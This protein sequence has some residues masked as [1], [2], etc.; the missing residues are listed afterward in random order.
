MPR[1]IFHVDM[2]AFFAAVE[3][4]DNPELKGKPVIVGGL[5]QRGVVS[6]ASYEARPF[7][8]HSALPMAKARQLCP[9]AHFVTPRMHAYTDA[10]QII[11]QTFSDFTPLVEPLSVDEAFLDMSGT[12]KLFGS[13]Q[14]TAQHI[15]DA[16][17]KKTQLT[18]SIGIAPN[19]F[20]AKLSSDMNKPD[21]ITNFMVD[22][23]AEKLAPLPLKKLWGVGPKTLEKLQS[24]GFHCFG[25]LQG[26]PPDTLSHHLGKHGNTLIALASGKDNRSVS[27]ASER[28]SIGSENTFNVDISGAQQVTSQLR[29]QCTGIAKELR[30]KGMKA[31]GVRIKIRYTQ[32][33]KTQTAQTKSTTGIQDSVTLYE[34]AITLLPRFN[35]NQRI[36]L[37]GMA[38]FDLTEQEAQPQMTLFEDTSHNPQQEKRETLEKLG[39]AIQHKFGTHT[40]ID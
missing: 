6:T 37:V 4:R 23:V 14:A 30:R 27:P 40:I 29:K 26:A 18:C 25:D 22:N 7:G 24:L 10:S 35:L 31:Q 9:H 33:F 5:G 15:K 39:D 38:A 16:I 1:V 3:Q 20:L 32:G 34:T 8:V 21:G 17:L 2:D 28:K 12:E 36:R 19:K 11:M 13:P